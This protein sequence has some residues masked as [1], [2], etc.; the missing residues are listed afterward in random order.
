MFIIINL[1]LN[2]CFSE[3]NNR[4]DHYFVVNRDNGL[5]EII[6]ILDKLLLKKD[7]FYSALFYNLNRNIYETETC[8]RK[9]KINKKNRK[10]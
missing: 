1:F 6:H 8:R 7:M 10:I 4:F 5:V 3:D 2:I 9:K